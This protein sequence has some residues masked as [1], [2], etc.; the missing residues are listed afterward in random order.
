MRKKAGTG[1]SHTCFYYIPAKL[2]AATV[3]LTVAAAI[4]F[5]LATAIILA[6]AAAVVAAFAAV[7]GANLNANI[8]LSRA[9]V[10]LAASGLA[11]FGF[12]T[13]GFA[14]V[15][16]A[17]AFGLAAL[18]LAAIPGFYFTVFIMCIAAVVVAATSFLFKT[19]SHG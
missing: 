1:C 14:A 16:L 2:I 10:F 6:V 12:T 19:R 3:V 8:T 11:A 18:G 17:A 5:T 4:V 15:L 13:F 9:A 7:A